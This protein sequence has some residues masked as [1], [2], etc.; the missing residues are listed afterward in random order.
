MDTDSLTQRRDH[1]T[2]DAAPGPTPDELR[3]ICAGLRPGQRAQVLEALSGA[4]SAARKPGLFP[5]A[6]IR[7][8]TSDQHR[9]VR[10]YDWRVA[11]ALDQLAATL[12]RRR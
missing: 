12:L 11:E 4:C 6:A 8:L 10:Q 7:S 2:L 1:A 5:L 3:H 9:P